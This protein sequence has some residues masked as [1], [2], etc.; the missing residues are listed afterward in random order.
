MAP[1]VAALN[2]KV[3][4]MKMMKHKSV[5]ILMTQLGVV[6]NNGMNLVMRGVGQMNLLLIIVEHVLLM[7][8][9][10]INVHYN[11]MVCITSQEELK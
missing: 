4:M 11:V 2:D 10:V 6:I 5:L 9:L 8:Q 1:D 7:N 3:Q